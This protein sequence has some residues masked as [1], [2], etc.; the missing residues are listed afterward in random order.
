VNAKLGFEWFQCT[1]IDN[2]ISRAVHGFAL[3]WSKVRRNFEQDRL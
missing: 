2:F 3:D 1:G